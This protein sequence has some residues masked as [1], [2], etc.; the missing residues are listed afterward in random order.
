M[1]YTARQLLL[2]V[3]FCDNDSMTVFYLTNHIYIVTK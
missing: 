3:F 1:Y 2:K